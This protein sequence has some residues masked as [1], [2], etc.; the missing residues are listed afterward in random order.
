MSNWTI[1]KKKKKKN[2]K[3]P[4]SKTNALLCECV[5]FCGKHSDTQSKKSL[6]FVGKFNFD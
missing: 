3:D 5:A 1:A 4:T 2:V 6:I